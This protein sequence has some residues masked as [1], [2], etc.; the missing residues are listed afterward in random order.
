LI[1]K[2]QREMKKDSIFEQLTTQQVSL[3]VLDT[4]VGGFTIIYL[5]STG[6]QVTDDWLR[7]MES[8]YNHLF[9]N[10]NAITIGGSGTPGDDFYIVCDNGDHWYNH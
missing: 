3:N 4:I 1:D 8:R 6:D 7:E 10:V 9:V 2:P 5:G